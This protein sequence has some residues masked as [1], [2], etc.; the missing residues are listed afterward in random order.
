MY[1]APERA[2]WLDVRSENLFRDKNF[3][4]GLKTCEHEGQVE[5]HVWPGG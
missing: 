4:Y 5:L 3:A 2:S 1:K